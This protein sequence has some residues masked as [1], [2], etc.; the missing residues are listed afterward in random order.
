MS[1]EKAETYEDRFT[2]IAPYFAVTILGIVII[3]VGFDAIDERYQ[4]PPEDL[5]NQLM[6]FMGEKEHAR[7]HA[8][9]TVLMEDMH[10]T[11]R[12]CHEHQVY[13]TAPVQ[14]FEIP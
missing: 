10:E 12:K 13:G 4:A 11:I 5:C 1:G 8:E 14:E 9:Y 3:I 2:K 7:Y 6:D